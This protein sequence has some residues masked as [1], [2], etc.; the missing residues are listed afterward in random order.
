MK[1]SASFDKFIYTLIIVN[2]IAMI[3]ESH[4]SIR[5]AYHSYFYVFET[6]SIVIF[7]FEYLFRIVVGY[8]NEGVRGVTKYMFSTF[9]LIDLISILPFYLNQFIKLTGVS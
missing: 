2:I 1:I 4:V 9:G 8:K 6:V 5:E 7:S 3:L